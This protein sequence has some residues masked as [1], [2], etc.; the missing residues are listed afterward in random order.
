[1]G[2]QSVRDLDWVSVGLRED[3]V[4][5]GKEGQTERGQGKVGKVGVCGGGGLAVVVRE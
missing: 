2:G 4:G 1:V 3:G 5:G